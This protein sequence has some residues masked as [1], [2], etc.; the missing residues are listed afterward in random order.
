MFTDPDQ[1]PSVE[2]AEGE[3]TLSLRPVLQVLWRRLWVV[4]LT[5]VVITGTV[6]AISKSQ[7]P[8]YQGYVRV[9]IGQDQSFA[10]SPSN[11]AGLQDLTGTMVEAVNTPSTAEGVMERLDFRMSAAQIFRNLNVE[12]VPETQFIEITFTHPDP[13]KARLVA[14]AT[15]EVFSEQ[16]SETDPGPD[17]VT[18]TV[19]GGASVSAIPISPKPTTNGFLA[20]VVSL[21]L[22]VGLAFL[23]E[24]LD[25]SW[26]LPPE[27][28]EQTF[29][30]PALGIIPKDSTNSSRNRKDSKLDEAVAEA[31]RTLGTNLLSASADTP[32][33]V[34]AITSSGL[35]EG[36][37]TTCARLGAGLAQANKSVLVA[38]CNFREP[39]IHKIFGVRNLLG[40]TD[41]L[42]DDSS[43]EAIWHDIQPGLKVLTVGPVPLN[44]T[45][46]F[47]SKRFAEF[48]RQMH[49][50]FDYVLLDT[51]P[52][53]MVSETALLVTSSDGVLLVLDTQSTSKRSV[54]RSVR[55]LQTAGANLLGIVLNNV[56][57]SNV[58][59]YG[60]SRD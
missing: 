50:R 36:T 9:L 19:W 13:E 34:I 14:Q 31:Y 11:V 16:I 52:V 58:G 28:V 40:M 30:V 23:L 43:P 5:V 27:E 45:E 55:S 46:L 59:Y 41:V 20:L 53:G 1:T 57:A 12:R 37:S 26:R 35:R 17:T 8:Q 39:A 48:M 25:D 4:V 18:A 6:V 33:K 10:E 7:T 49:D 3:Y 21:C 54:L 24:Y 22:G 60:Y 51:P 15:A 42:M 56:K 44:P 2:G 32:P 29:G 47:S 38:D